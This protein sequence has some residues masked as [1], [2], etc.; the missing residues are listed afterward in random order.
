MGDAPALA[1][2]QAFPRFLYP[3]SLL[4]SFSLGFARKGAFAIV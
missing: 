1:V 4:P 3:A 2:S